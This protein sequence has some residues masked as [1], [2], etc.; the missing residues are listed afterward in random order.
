MANKTCDGNCLGCSFQQQMYCAAQRSYA[1]SKNQETMFSHLAN[2]E[3]AISAL[4]IALERFNGDEQIINPFDRSLEATQ[5]DGGVENRP[6][7]Q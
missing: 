3:E 5:N 1:I 7:G 4:E 6:S 2:I